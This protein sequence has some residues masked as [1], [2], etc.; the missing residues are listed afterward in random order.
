MVVYILFFLFLAVL[1]VI[2]HY[3]LHRLLINYFL[4]ILGLE[5]KG[6]KDI[7]IDR[8]QNNF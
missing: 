5:H 8:L 2:L 1:I 3:Q 6:N 4:D 7:R